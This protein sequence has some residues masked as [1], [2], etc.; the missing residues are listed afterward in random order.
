MRK[1][2]VL[3]ACLVMVPALA[4][5]QT[6]LKVSLG[7]AKLAWDAGVPGPNETLATKHVITCGPLTT[8]VLMPAVTIPVKDVVPGPGTYDCTIYAVND[9]DRQVDP[10][11]AF[12]QF[13]A[14]NPPPK[15]TNFRLEVK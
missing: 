10:D 3:L 15:A 4:Q 9:F 7:S 6:T 5:A 8:E 12:P 2:F 13:Q 1:C 11:G 14:G